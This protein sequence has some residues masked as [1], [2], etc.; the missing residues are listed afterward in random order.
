MMDRTS[1]CEKRGNAGA[2]GAQA[3]CQC[4][5]GSQLNLELATEVHADGV[6]V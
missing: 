1:W 4:A 5:L 2:A 3:L 6:M